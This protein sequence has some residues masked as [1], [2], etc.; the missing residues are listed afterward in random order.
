MSR[1]VLHLDVNMTITAFDSYKPHA[2]SEI[3]SKH[4]ASASWVAKKSRPDAVA[5]DQK[6]GYQ[7]HPL[8]TECN[9]DFI[10]GKPSVLAPPTPEGFQPETVVN[11]Y[12]FLKHVAVHN[13]VVHFRQHSRFS[14]ACNFTKDGFPGSIFQEQYAAIKSK[15]LWP[16]HLKSDPHFVLNCPRNAPHSQHSRHQ[17]G[18]H[19]KEGRDVACHFLLPSFCKLYVQLLES[20]RPFTIILRTFGMDGENVMN[21]MAKLTLGEHP[22]FPISE[23]H[24]HGVHGRK[25]VHFIPH[26][27]SIERSEHRP[28]VLTM[29]ERIEL[30]PKAYQ[31]QLCNPDITSHARQAGSITKLQ[32]IPR[33][34]ML[35]LDDYDHWSYRGCCAAAGKSFEVDI[36]DTQKHVVFFDD[37]LWFDPDDSAVN[38]VIR[39]GEEHYSPAD[40][41]VFSE[42]FLVRAGLLESVLNEDYFSEKI[43]TTEANASKL[44]ASHGSARK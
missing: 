7:P 5:P 36:N 14:W 21:A 15:L 16:S 18:H 27:I 6:P 12:D 23:D 17:H 43:H 42:V 3:V 25:N 40:Q 41:T 9:Y 44:R 28:D 4:L 32:G 30:L 19:E 31:D 39:D 1:L 34:V 20:S 22:L 24:K 8:L 13:S 38:L 33:S 37:N 11:F 2:L 29:D 35:L 26:P 10:S